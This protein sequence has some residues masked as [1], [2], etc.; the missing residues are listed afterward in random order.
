MKVEMKNGLVHIYTNPDELI[1]ITNHLMLG[2]DELVNGFEYV[3]HNTD[4]KEDERCK[5]ESTQN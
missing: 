1:K 3:I 5:A 2:Y 4:R